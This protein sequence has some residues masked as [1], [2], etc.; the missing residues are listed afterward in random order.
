MPLFGSKAATRPP[1]PAPVPTSKPEAPVPNPNLHSATRRSLTK[2]LADVVH[3]RKQEVPPPQRPKINTSPS[4][5]KPPLRRQ[6]SEDPG[7]SSTAV[8]SSSSG[9]KPRNVIGKSAS[10]DQTSPLKQSTNTLVNPPSPTLTIAR[11]AALRK[12]KA[13][14]ADDNSS[15]RP[16]SAA[17]RTPI[18]RALGGRQGTESPA[19]AGSSSPSSQTPSPTA[20]RRVK[21]SPSPSVRTNPPVVAMPKV[22]LEKE[23]AKQSGLR[24][25]KARPTSAIFLGAASMPPPPPP[26]TAQAL[27]EQNVQANERLSASTSGNRPVS[28]PASSA[29]ANR[30]APEPS[31]YPERAVSP[32]PRRS[33]RNMPS[34]AQSLASAAQSAASETDTH[35]DANAKKGEKAS[36]SEIEAASAPTKVGPSRTSTLPRPN[37]AIGGRTRQ[38]IGVPPHFKSNVG[39]RTA[40]ESSERTLLTKRRRSEVTPS[41]LGSASGSSNPLARPPQFHPR[42]VTRHST[43]PPPAS[44]APGPTTPRSSTRSGANSNAAQNTFSVPKRRIAATPLA[45]MTFSGIPEDEDEIGGPD[46]S[47]HFRLP[48]SLSSRHSTTTA[49]D[50]DADDDQT[51]NER[52]NSQL[53]FKQPSKSTFP[54]NQT[55]ATLL[56]PPQ[57]RQRT[58]TLRANTS[59]QNVTA[60]R[61][62][63]TLRS[64]PHSPFSSN[65][66]RHSFMPLEASFERSRE[67]ARDTD[68]EDGI[69]ENMLR[70]I[71]A[72]FVPSANVS[73]I[74]DESLLV[75]ENEMHELAGMGV[76]TSPSAATSMSVGSPASVN[77]GRRQLYNGGR[78]GYGAGSESGYNISRLIFDPAGAQSARSGAISPLD[79]HD[80]APRSAPKEDTTDGEGA[81]SESLMLKVRVSSLE[82]ELEEF[83]AHFEERE[84]ITL[85]QQTRI[86]SLE[87]EL[88]TV[89]SVTR[90]RDAKNIIIQEELNTEIAAMCLGKAA[91]EWEAVGAVASDEVQVVKSE[92]AMLKMMLS[93]L[94]V[95]LFV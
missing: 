80:S 92:R 95:C 36:A 50:D 87:S 14:D 51:T 24:Q 73:V 91:R 79:S 33:L 40:S 27:T 18:V 5:I 22:V 6:P 52:S 59:T 7:D 70:D 72:P 88:S 60:R 28:R 64:R 61:R 8:E 66:P 48:G 77:P 53:K 13:S 55:K 26:G 86:S 54:S 9:N 46:D 94:D 41:M 45:D 81:E 32:L 63:P 17:A 74:S 37:G 4:A 82:A 67:Y 34:V 19:R 43:P 62:R 35:S 49:D 30:G 12:N 85:T 57:Q 31:K 84:A 25:P 11:T 76:L 56:K 78:N 10:E 39:P 29:T 20:S 75:N 2:A 15:S 42:E 83:H 21:K 58:T 68:D 71:S 89:Y 47:F 3:S 69:M 90:A 93:S 65:N 16:G 44:N 1:Q 23:K 38:S